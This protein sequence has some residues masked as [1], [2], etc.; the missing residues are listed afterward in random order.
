VHCREV[1]GIWDGWVV[2]DVKVRD[3]I[4]RPSMRVITTLNRCM[5]A[6][7]RLIRI[8]STVTRVLIC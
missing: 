2:R 4:R 5:I 8:Y 7:V 3:K 1:T 6:C